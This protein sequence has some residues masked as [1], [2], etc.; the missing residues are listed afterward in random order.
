VKSR[1]PFASTLLGVLMLVF[2]LGLAPLQHVHDPSTIVRCGDEYWLFATGAGIISW[3]ST[4]LIHWR[5]GPSV[6]SQLPRWTRGIDARQM[7]YFWAPEVVQLNGQYLLYYVVSRWGQRTS[8]IGLATNPTLD[9]GDP[10][11]RWTDH[12][13]VIRS[14][15]KDDFNALDPGIFNDTDGRMWMT[16]GSFWTGIKLTELDP[17]TGLRKTGAPLYAVAS[18]KEIEA[19]YLTKHGGQ[20]YLFVN[21]GLC[22]RGVN[23]TYN[24]RV[25]RASRVTGPYLDKNGVDM[26]SGGG[27]LFLG[28]EGPRI[29][30]GQVGIL[31]EGGREW[32]SYHYYDARHGG[33]A[34]LGLRELTWDAAGWP[35]AGVNAADI[36]AR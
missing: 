23:S 10:A 2:Y 19:S 28:T 30:P 7:G 31:R 29:G 14:T 35:V 27:T 8:A 24:I 34:S 11:Y 13:I 5:Q 3:H 33:L 17:S 36:L 18:A 9:P 20:Y 22:C 16:L 32:V 21:W 1:W 4:D 25:G 6:F 26:M 15:Q 12:G